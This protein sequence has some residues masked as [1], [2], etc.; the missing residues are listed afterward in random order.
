MK[1]PK[2]SVILITYNHEKY[3]RQALEGFV[4]Q[5]TKFLFKVYVHD[6]ASTDQTRK[7][8][9]EYAELFLLE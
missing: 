3:I 9:C 6:D 4:R 7:I 1:D 2:L 8:I 5:R